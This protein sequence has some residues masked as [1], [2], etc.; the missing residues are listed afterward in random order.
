[1]ETPAIIHT[2]VR[3]DDLAVL[4]Y[5]GGTTGT[6][7]GVMLTHANIF[8]NVVQT[9]AFMYPNRA[10]GEARYVMV[11]PYF[12]VYAFT[13]GMMTGVWMGALQVLIPKFDVEIVLEA[14]REYRPTYF[15]AVPTLFV[16]LLAHPRLKAYGLNQV[17]MFNS[18]GA[19]CPVDV[20]ER[21]ERTV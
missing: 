2:D 17:R 14:I 5:T 3:P 13:V 10:R 12:H 21:W 18:G 11:I 1:I 15:P 19:P 7:K 9:E 8:A 4:Q 20:I 6:P 16:S